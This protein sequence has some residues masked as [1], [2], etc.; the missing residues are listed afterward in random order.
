MV[1]ARGIVAGGDS[2]DGVTRRTLLAA[3]AGVAAAAALH[4]WPAAPALSVGGAP[5]AAPYLRRRTW[6]A[7]TDGRLTTATGARIDL[8]AVHDLSPALAGHDDAFRLVFAGPDDIG[9]GI[10]QL[11]HA[12]LG[13]FALFL[14]PGAPGRLSAVVNRVTGRR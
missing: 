4:S 2:T 8:L 10:Q 5:A 14:A 6:S 3:G 13:R 12:E 1:D 7:L 9:Q 11:E